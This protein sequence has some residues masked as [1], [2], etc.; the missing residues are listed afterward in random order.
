[1]E[2]GYSSARG[3]LR[4]HGRTAAT[5]VFPCKERHEPNNRMFLSFSLSAATPSCPALSCYS[6][7]REFRARTALDPFL[8]PVKPVPEI[9][10]RGFAF[11]PI[12]GFLF[13]SATP[14]R[15]FVTPRPE[16]RFHRG[17]TGYPNSQRSEEMKLSTKTCLNIGLLAVLT[18][19]WKTCF[20]VEMDSNDVSTDL[21]DR[22]ISTMS[23][24]GQLSTNPTRQR[25]IEMSYACN[26]DPA[27]EKSEQQA[28]QVARKNRQEIRTTGQAALRA[29]C[30]RTAG[31]VVRCPARLSE[32][33]LPPT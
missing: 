27:R 3:A 16:K 15:Q 12:F 8:P 10:S 24:V 23:P 20:L 5:T 32:S 17:H 26:T 28:C 25:T 30:P 29:Q 7:G 13:S 11:F 4:P 33:C 31:Q 9:F 18:A 2:R 14:V 19:F 22:K 21:T 1:M 6:E